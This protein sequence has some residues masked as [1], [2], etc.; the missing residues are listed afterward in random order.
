MRQ[1]GVDTLITEEPDD[2]IG[3]VRI[4]GGD[5]QQWLSLPGLFHTMKTMIEE[6]TDLVT[7]KERTNLLFGLLSG[8]TYRQNQ[9][10]EKLYI[11]GTINKVDFTGVTIKDSVFNN[12]TFH[13][14]GAD[15]D[16]LFANSRFS[17]EL[18]FEECD[19]RKWAL[20]KLDSCDLEPPTN[21]VWEGVSDQP[22][23]N[24]DEHIFDALNLALCKFWHHGR[25][26]ATIRK[27]DWNKGT[28][29]H[30]V[31]C[32][33]LLR[34]M[35][36]KGLVSEAHI[37]GVQEGGYC[38]DRKAISDLQRFMDNRQITGRI[39]EVYDTLIQKGNR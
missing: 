2:R 3:Q 34:S 36:S 13:K 27:N 7:I 31:Y 22:V 38:F 4:C 10:L 30:S 33:P 39:K 21:L 1:S 14:C 6:R 25:F 23:S 24:K 26:K 9:L 5:G 32:K 20:V 18:N 15:E 37:S 17:G 35:L 8:S 19:R 11:I 28:L 12:V 16:T 29:G